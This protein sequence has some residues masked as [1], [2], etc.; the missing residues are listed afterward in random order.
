MRQRV[1]K[2]LLRLFGWR[3]VGDLPPGGGFVA[4]VA[5]HTSNWDFP[6]GLMVAASFGFKASWLG[7]DTLFRRPFGGLMRRLGGIPV[8]R[9][10]GAGAVESAAAAFADDESLVLAIAPEGTRSPLPFWRSGFYH[11]AVAA[12]VPIYPVRIDR[13]SRTWAAGPAISPTGDI[14]RDMDEV[15]GFYAGMRG[16]KPDNAGVVA[17]REEA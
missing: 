7:K 3:T 6:L 12:A 5:P 15:R 13:P 11:I 1:G 17:L 9:Q 2:G 14:R 16:I 10:G 4:I 8:Q